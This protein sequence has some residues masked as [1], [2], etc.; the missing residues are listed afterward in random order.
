MEEKTKKRFL[1]FGIITVIV[2]VFSALAVIRKD[3][4]RKARRLSM[5]SVEIQEKPKPKT[6]LAYQLAKIDSGEFVF[7]YDPQISIFNKLLTKLDSYYIEN[8]QEIF[9]ASVAG[10][11]MLKKRGIR[12]KLQ[13]VMGGLA[14][15]YPYK[16]PNQEYI[17]ILST[18]VTLQSNGNSHSQAIA[19]LKALIKMRIE[20]RGRRT[21]I[22]PF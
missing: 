12:V 16:I 21:S 3:N 14:N 5:S 7:R 2:I 8:K 1:I 4:S 13:F 18:Y 11:N 6:D 17:K 22:T 19:G 15:I 20:T 9:D 10:Q